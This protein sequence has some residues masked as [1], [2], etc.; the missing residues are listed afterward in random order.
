MLRRRGGRLLFT[1]VFLVLLFGSALLGLRVVAYTL[2]PFP[3]R[4]VITAEARA[5]DLEPLLV[6][7][8]IRVESKFQPDRV[9]S[10]DARGLMQVVPETGL[11]VAEQMN[12]GPIEADD[13][14]DVEVNVAIGTW[15]LASLRDEFDQNLVAALAAYNGGRG[16]VNHWMEEGVWDGHLD[17]LDRIPYRETREFVRRVL[18]DYQ[19]Y[20]WLYP[21]L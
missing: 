20:R 17:T 18:D 12:I 15:Y 8:V 2:Y 10:R 19:I 7:A 4:E 21:D 14:F 13:L 1:L 9:S 3:Y 11:W 6:A 16:N 5:N